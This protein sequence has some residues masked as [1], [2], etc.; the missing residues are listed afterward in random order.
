MT[1]GELI[2]Y[3]QDLDQDARVYFMSQPSWPF[4]YSIRGVTTRSEF[5]DIDSEENDDDHSGKRSGN[6]V[7]L[8]EGC[9]LRYGSK[10]AWNVV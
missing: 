9:Q 2:E 10:D 7:F 1:V 8:V 6:D 3:L 5:E 4:E